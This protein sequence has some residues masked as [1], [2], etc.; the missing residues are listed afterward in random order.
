MIPKSFLMSTSN[1]EAHLRHCERAG[2]MNL[3]M[4]SK[5]AVCC[6]NRPLLYLTAHLRLTSN[7]LTPENMNTILSALNTSVSFALDIA[8]LNQALLDRTQFHEGAI[9]IHGDKVLVT[10]AFWKEVVHIFFSLFEAACVLWFF[11]CRSLPYWWTVYCLDGKED[12]IRTNIKAKLAEIHRSLR[13]LEAVL[14]NA[15]VNQIERP[16]QNMITPMVNCVEGMVIEINE[17]PNIKGANVESVTLEM[18]V[19]AIG[20][21]NSSSP[22]LSHSVKQ[23]PWVFM[24]LLGEQV[25]GHLRWRSPTEGRWRKFWNNPPIN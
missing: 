1:F 22:D 3:N 15:D 4:F 20:A 17:P 5:A 21:T 7:L 11:S 18:E 23:D 13:L 6:L 8:D 9:E 10:P 16:K 14:S 24:G 25:N 12:F 2:L 19:L